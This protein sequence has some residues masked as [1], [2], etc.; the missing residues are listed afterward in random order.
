MIS[1][2]NAQRFIDQGLDFMVTELD[3]S[4]PMKDGKPID[5]ADIQKQGLLYRLILEYVLH[6]SPKCPAML[7][8]GFTDHYSWLPAYWNYTRGDGLP[9]DWFYQPKPAYW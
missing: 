8:W 9:L 6:F 4:I 3:I 7:T 2:Q 5:P 1:Y